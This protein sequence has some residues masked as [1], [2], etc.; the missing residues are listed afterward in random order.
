MIDVDIQ[1]YIRSGVGRGRETE[2]IGPFLATFSPRNDN[3]YLNYAVPVDG[4]LPT[5]AEVTSLIAAYEL[6]GR[7]PRLEYL[8]SVAPAVEEALVAGGFVVEGRLPIMVCTSGSAQDLPV[9]P[10]IELIVPTSEDE[11]RAMVTA[12]NEAYGEDAPT[13]AQVVARLANLAAG[14][15]AILACDAATGQPAG[16]GTCDVPLHGTTEL[17]GVGVRDAFRRRGIAGALTSRLARDA[18]GSGL[19]TVFLTPAHE[20]E[21]RIYARAGFIR[22][23]EQLHIARP[24]R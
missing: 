5:A 17:A 19:M 3:P 16:G 23:S 14:G 4:A 18:F 2:Q 20:A 6:R 12:Q 22:I 13:Q 1:A 7:L 9:P 21:E 11:I 10:G 8:T 24:R 15:L